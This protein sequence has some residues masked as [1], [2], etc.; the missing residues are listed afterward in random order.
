M[1]LVVGQ[2]VLPTRFGSAAADVPFRAFPRT[3]FVFGTVATA[4]GGGVNNILWENGRLSTSVDDDSLD[5]IQQ[6]FNGA[7]VLRPI[8]SRSA[9]YYGFG[10]MHYVRTQNGAGA[11]FGFWL[12]KL[13]NGAGYYEIEENLVEPVPGM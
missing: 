3:A 11:T 8:D 12:V 1:A 9:E 6:D 5:L 2:I 13:L 4:P 10:V 7:Q